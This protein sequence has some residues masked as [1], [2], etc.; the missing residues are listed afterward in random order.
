MVVVVVVVEYRNESDYGFD[1]DYDYDND[2]ERPE[3]FRSGAPGS[4]RE[5][6]HRRH[7]VIAKKKIAM[8]GMWGVGKTSLVRRFSQSVFDEKYHAT[9]GVKIDTKLVRCS[10]DKQINM[11]LWDIAG[12]EDEYSVPIHYIQGAAGYLLVID[13]TRAQ[14]LVRGQEL[15][16]T[17]EQKIGG[18]PFVV[19][20][21]KSDLAWKMS[22]N[23]VERVMKPLGGT[24]YPSSAKTGENV[25]LAFLNLAQAL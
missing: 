9:I 20:V 21:N 17:V 3:G 15:A 22:L 2:N 25:E 24:V 10:D 18:L 4:S 7:N 5:A 11:I 6:W 16:T 23:E 8:L 1:Y 12:A 14:T 13:G 19:A